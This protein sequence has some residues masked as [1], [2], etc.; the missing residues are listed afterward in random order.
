M[1]IELRTV[2]NAKEFALFERDGAFFARVPAKPHGGQANEKLL[3][4]LRKRFGKKVAL[5]SGSKSRTKK[6][7]VETKSEEEERE[8]E[9]SFFAGVAKPGQKR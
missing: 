4:C 1:F 3:E 2:P 6:I 9:K 7:F 5:V 8:V